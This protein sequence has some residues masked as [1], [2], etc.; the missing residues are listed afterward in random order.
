MYFTSRI[1]LLICI[2]YFQV[3]K[4]LS[5]Q[6]ATQRNFT[7][8]ESCKPANRRLNRYGDVH[9]YDHSRIVLKRGD[10]DYINANLV[11]VRLIVI[12][13]NLIIT[14]CRIDGQSQSS[15]YSD[16]RTTSAHRF[17]LLGDG[18]GTEFHGYSDAKQT[19]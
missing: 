17:T 8:A 5:Y 19:D 16:T 3:I 11:E 10:T 1:H 13:V 7:Y 9:P 4:E 14:N 6:E 18:V 12:T 2:V 15:L